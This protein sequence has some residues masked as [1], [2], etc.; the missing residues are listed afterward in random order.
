MSNKTKT[1]QVSETK[2]WKELFPNKNELLGSHNLTDNEFLIAEISD[3]HVGE[4]RN[5]VGTL[6]KKPM[7]FFT[8]VPPMILNVTN[9]YAIE[10]MYGSHYPEWLGKKVQIFR[11]LNPSKIGGSH[12]LVVSNKAPEDKKELTKDSPRFQDAVTAFKRD[13]NL[14]AVLKHF[15]ISKDVQKLIIEAGK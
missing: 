4:F 15:T 9:S 13:G 3:V 14:K 11:A 12:K 1:Y 5:Q 6:E 2:H 10:E 7:V 8:Q